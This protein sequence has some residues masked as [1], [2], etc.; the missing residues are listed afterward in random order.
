MQAKILK[1]A[2]AA[3]EP[4]QRLGFKG[5]AALAR[6]L[7]QDRLG[8]GKALVKAGERDRRGLGGGGAVANQ[9][10]APGAGKIVSA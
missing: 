1:R 2:Q 9:G 10:L 3:A 4:D 7:G 6:A 5:V 8:A